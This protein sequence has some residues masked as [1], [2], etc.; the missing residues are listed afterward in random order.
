MTIHGWTPLCITSVTVSMDIT[1][2]LTIHDHPQMDTTVHT[3]PSQCPWMSHAYCDIHGHCDRRVCT[4]VSIHGWP[5]MVTATVTS[6]DT[7]TEGARL[8]LNLSYLVP[9]KM[10]SSSSTL[11]GTPLVLMVEYKVC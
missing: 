4:V 1:V 6:M 7:V 9:P 3:P 8:E 11:A 10:Q 2:A 5:W